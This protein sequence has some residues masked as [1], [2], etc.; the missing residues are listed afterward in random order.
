MTIE[1]VNLPDPISKYNKTEE[2][3]S[4]PKKTQESDSISL[5]EEA[6]QKAELYKATE[7]AKMTPSV[8]KDRIEEVKKKLEDPS[9]IDEKV[10]ETVA[11]KIMKYFEI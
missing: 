1:K 5:S 11:D 10:I 8:R 6:K 7:V 4:K 2:S 9:Y 3:K